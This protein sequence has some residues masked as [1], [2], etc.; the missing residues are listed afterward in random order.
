M[1]NNGKKLCFRSTGI[2]IA[3]IAI[4]AFAAGFLIK[5]HLQPS[6]AEAE[7]KNAGGET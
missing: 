5:S 7:H 1:E 2:K 6:P 4:I 3:F